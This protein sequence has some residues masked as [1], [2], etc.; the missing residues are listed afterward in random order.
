MK[1]EQRAVDDLTTRAA[2]IRALPPAVQNREATLLVRCPRRALLLR[3]F[4]L[5]SGELFALPAPG[6]L[7]ASSWFVV[8]PDTRREI[9]ARCRCCS[10]GLRMVSSEV[11]T[12]AVRAGN[13]TL[14]LR[15]L[16]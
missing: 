14:T 3:V 8:P 12:A 9:P 6:G 15:A 13:R 4:R 16:D 11:I 5:G 7:L 2:Q 10:G 1:S